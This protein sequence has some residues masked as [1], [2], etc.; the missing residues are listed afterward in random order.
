MIIVFENYGKDYLQKFFEDEGFNVDI[1]EQDNQRCAEIE[2][3][4]DGGVDMIINLIPFTKEEFIDYVNDFDVDD[5]ID[6]YRQDVN[7]KKNF[8]I[9][10]S[11][12]DFKKFHSDLKKV[13]KKIQSKNFIIN[14]KTW[15]YNI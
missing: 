4:T 12:K 3:W 8:T 5:L 6:T 9:S 15:K 2:K 10:Q 14:Q 13:V 7:Y 11:L 1:F